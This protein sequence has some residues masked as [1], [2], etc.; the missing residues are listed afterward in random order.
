M[1]ADT[2]RGVRTDISLG[3]KVPFLLWP[4]VDLLGI[5]GLV[6]LGGGVAIYFGAREA[7]ASRLSA[8][9]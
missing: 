6:A 7:G 1:N 9:P 8:P 5:G 2:A 3:A 4:G